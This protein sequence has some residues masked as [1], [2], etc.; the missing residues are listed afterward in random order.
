MAQKRGLGAGRGVQR[1]LDDK[2]QVVR[3]HGLQR[4]LGRERLAG[5]QGR[6]D[7]DQCGEHGGT[8][9]IDG[10]IGEHGCQERLLRHGGKQCQQGNLERADT[11]RCGQH[12]PGAEREQ[13]GGQEGAKTNLQ[14]VGQHRPEHAPCG[15]RVDGR[16][17]E[18]EGQGP[19]RRDRQAGD[20][21]GPPDAEQNEGI[22]GD[23]HGDGKRP[24]MGDGRAKGQ[25]GPCGHDR[26]GREEG[27]GDDGRNARRVAQSQ[28]RQHAPAHERACQRTHADGLS[29]GD[30]CHTGPGRPRRIGVAPHKAVHDDVIAPER[31]EADA[32][33]DQAE[34]PLRRSD[35]SERRADMVDI[36]LGQLVPQQERE[37]REHREGSH[38]TGQHPAQPDP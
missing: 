37:D 17:A 3:V 34:R 35:R 38:L 8:G 30:G 25:H 22:G 31:P 29:D 12:E 16:E 27:Q 11:P 15:E 10:A 5:A 26:P 4:R 18:D 21:T 13:V 6:P 9:V 2:G 7:Q 23:E 14:P 28:P 24:R 33:Q 36:E 20:G 19:D 32:G 1:R